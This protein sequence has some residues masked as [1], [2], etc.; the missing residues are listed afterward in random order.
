MIPDHDFKFPMI[1]W[2]VNILHTV[3]L[4][5]ADQVWVYLAKLNME[6]KAGF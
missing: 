6:R 5:L 1:Y 4:T 3:L 2:A